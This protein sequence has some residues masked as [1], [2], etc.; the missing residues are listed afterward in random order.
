MYSM[1]VDNILVK[2]TK[3]RD[4]DIFNFQQRINY[5]YKH[6]KK[7]EVKSEDNILEVIK[8]S[9]KLKNALLYKVVY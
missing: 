7:L 8:T 1:L 9:L 5:I 4:E 3:E 2:F 6:I